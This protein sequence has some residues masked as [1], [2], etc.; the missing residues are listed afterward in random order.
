MEDGAAGSVSVGALSVR[1]P[2]PTGSATVELVVGGMHC[3]SCAALIEE[4]LT[5]DPA[6]RRVTVDLDAARASVTYDPATL[7]VDDVCAAVTGVG[8][9]ATRTAPAAPGS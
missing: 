7:T 5:A 8:Y 2:D 9:S 6:V 4:T 1:E 3:Q